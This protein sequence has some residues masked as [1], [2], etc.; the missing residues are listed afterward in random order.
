MAIVVID[1]F[2]RNAFS[3]VIVGNIDL[4][5]ILLVVVFFSGYSIA[6]VNKKHI[7]VSVIVDK[8]PPRLQD[9]IKLNGHFLT[10]GI[11]IFIC[12]QFLFYQ[13]FTREN[14]II[15]GMLDIPW[16][17]IILLCGILLFIFIITLLETILS[18]LDKYIKTCNSKKHYLYLLPGTILI[19]VLLVYP[20]L[21]D[22]LVFSIPR[23]TWGIICFLLLFILIFLNVHIFASMAVVSLVGLAFIT[24]SEGGLGTLVL[25]PLAVGREYTWSVGPM[26]VWMGLIV[27]HAG[28]A[29]KLYRAAYNWVGQMSGGLASATVI[30]CAGLA[31]VVG[32]T[33]TGVL[34]MGNIALPQMKKYGYDVSLATGCIA[35]G[36]TIGVLIPPSFMFIVYGMM[37]EVSIGQ[38]FIAGIFPGLLLTAALVLTIWIRCRL[39]PKLGP[40]APRTSFKMKVVSLAPVWPVILLVVL[41]LG[42]I[43]TGFFTPT[44]A[45]AIGAFG[46]LLIAFSQKKLNRNNINASLIGV[47]ETIGIV[48]SIFV[49]A[50]AF[51]HFIAFTGLP[52]LV[53]DFVVSLNLS[54]FAITVLILIFYMFLG[55]VMNSLPAVLLTLPIIFPIATAAGLDPLLLGVLIV[56]EI[57]LGTLTPPI[58]MNVFAMHAVAKD[59]PLYTIFRGILPFWLTFFF[60][61]FILAMFPQISLFLPSLMG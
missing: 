24:T 54:Q 44:E 43:Y 32:D 15:T 56:V 41:C 6:Q 10:I 36:A 60:F 13:N 11:T 7:Q 23:P 57:E 49:F 58:G 61:L 26:F 52:Q 27:F 14:K 53:A 5:G 17:P 16:W 45:G 8:L 9:I 51:S 40:A 38:L 25:T 47:V 39:N 42:G 31:A 59:V 33:I 46:S 2:L 48:M 3:K 1:V 30:A 21:A 22:S 18:D 28:F 55:C 4:L 37:T 35:A 19:I 20:L 12:L 50:M 29:I 34:T